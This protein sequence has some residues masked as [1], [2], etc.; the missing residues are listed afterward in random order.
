MLCKWATTGKKKAERGEGFREGKK[1]R[2][3]RD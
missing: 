1:K 2:G 3:G